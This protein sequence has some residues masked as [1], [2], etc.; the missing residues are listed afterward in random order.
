MSFSFEWKGD[1]IARWAK[2]QAADI[3]SKDARQIER[4]M[5]SVKCP[6]HGGHANVKRVKTADGWKVSLAEPCCDKLE[7]AVVD[8]RDREVQRMS[9]AG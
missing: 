8:A 1:D 6:E 7:Q 5:R 2:E 4:V 3:V 9:R